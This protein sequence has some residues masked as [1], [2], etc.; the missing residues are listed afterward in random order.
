MGEERKENGMEMNGGKQEDGEEGENKERRKKGSREGRKDRM[1]AIKIRGK[2]GV[3]GMNCIFEPCQ[4]SH[5]RD[6]M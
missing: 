2:E 6:A 5:E 1:N 3:G 4:R